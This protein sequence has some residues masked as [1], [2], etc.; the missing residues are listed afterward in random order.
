[1]MNVYQLNLLDTPVEPDFDDLTVLSARVLNAPVALL[2]LIDEQ[3][4]RQFF[5]SQ[6]GLPEPVAS[7]RQTPLSH[8]FCKLVTRSSEMLRVT[9]AHTDPRVWNNPAVTELGV[10]AYLGQ[11]IFAPD[12][13]PIG[14]LCVIEGQTR[15]WTDEEADTLL[16]LS[17]MAAARIALRKSLADKEAEHRHLD[18]L[19][20][21]LPIGVTT[22]D[23]AGRVM[24]ANPAA[25]RLFGVGRDQSDGRTFDDPAWKITTVDGE[26]FPES[27]LPI[28]RIFGGEE[29]VQDVVHA[30][31]RPDGQRRFVSVDAARSNRATDRTAVVCAISDVTDRILAK[32]KLQD[33]LER[34]EAASRAKSTFLAN[35]S[36]E[37]RTPLTGILGLTELLQEQSLPEDASRIVRT[38]HQSGEALL[39]VVNSVLDLS[40]IEAGKLA[41]HPKP[42]DVAGVLQ[43]QHRLFASLA[44]R[45]G[46]CFPPP[47]IDPTLELMRLGDDFRVSQIIG[48]LLSNA[49]KFTAAGA[50]RL[51][52]RQLEGDWLE[53]SV[54]DT[55]SGI[56]E[57]HLPR[58]MKEFEQADSSSARSQYGTGL[59]LAI[60]SKL[61]ELMAGTLSI[62]STPGSGTEVS[63]RLE[64]PRIAARKDMERSHQQTDRAPSDVA[65][66]RV[67][68][69]EDNATNMLILKKMLQALNVEAV[70]ARNGKE[71][72]EAWEEA[73]FDVLL[74]DISM[75]ILDGVEALAQIRESTAAQGL[76]MP[77]AIAATANVLKNQENSYIAAGFSDIL[78][79]PFR[80]S[81]L[82]EVLG[83]AHVLAGISRDI[84]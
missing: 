17:K 21:T 40:Q 45:K 26:P 79:K 23:D 38:I 42:F 63:L 72:C 4:D 24:F 16:K 36:H 8:S 44:V 55:G 1:M 58:I 75:P 70:F 34:S 54:S 3:G 74:F 14:S 9:D 53:F 84:S 76:P 22:V 2:S 68:V 33:A 18:K 47:E 77:Y 83:K 62:V 67:L 28:A 5:K 39:N 31:A 59:G 64:F 25:S 37:V 46:V 56:A 81:D 41:L 35:I 20:E 52:V 51:G 27:E 71:A 12:G 15:D 30:I 6:Y 57:D 65:G 13:T 49:V 73:V 32:Q 82:L 10:I 66:L 50:V 78:P 7:R 19:L 61:A 29:K 43:Q 60:V 11:P 80:K 48:N 69:A